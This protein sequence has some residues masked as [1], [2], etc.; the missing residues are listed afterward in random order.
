[1]SDVPP[2]RRIVPVL[3]YRDAPAAIRWL[4][5]AFGFEPQLVVDDAR[6]GVTHA[7]LVSGETLVM[8]ASAS[9]E[10]FGRFQKPPPDPEAPATASSY[11][12]VPDADR[13]H[14]RA[15]AAGA[16]IVLPLEDQSYGGRGYS[17]RD[18]EGHLW[19]FGTYDP[20]PSDPSFRPARAGEAGA[21]RVAYVNVFVTDLEQALGF[22]HDDLRLA[23]AR[24]EP[25]HGYAALDAGPVRLGLAVAAAEHGALVG[26]HTGIGLAVEDLAAEHARLVARGVEFEMPPTHQP[27]G[28]F[29]ALVRDPDGN[30]LYL[31]EVSAVHRG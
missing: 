29:L 16:R 30:L 6:G 8:V 7:Q 4:Q 5:R 11:V 2:A 1:M 27:W 22:Y 18:P 28:G 25:E 20:L 31:D 21:M 14:A 26:R 9:D 15:T 23:V 3:R 10:G 24:A 12:V 19:S 13:H 17:C